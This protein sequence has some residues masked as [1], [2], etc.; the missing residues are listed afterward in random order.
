[1]DRAFLTFSVLCIDLDSAKPYT[2]ITGAVN[3]TAKYL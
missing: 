3:I 2:N 1:M